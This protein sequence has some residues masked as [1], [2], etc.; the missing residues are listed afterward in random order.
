MDGEEVVQRLARRF[1]S[2]TRKELRMALYERLG[3][4]V[5]SEGQPALNVIATVASDA[6]GK[7]DPG[8]YF[9]FV[10]MRRLMDR[11]L[12]EAPQL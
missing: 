8:R 5:E 9:A 12:I 6:D 11:G 10:V 3:R 4:L 1:G 7:R 2:G